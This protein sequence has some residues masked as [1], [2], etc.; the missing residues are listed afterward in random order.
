MEPRK[1]AVD[2]DDEVFSWLDDR[3]FGLAWDRDG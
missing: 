2:L 3:R 1:A